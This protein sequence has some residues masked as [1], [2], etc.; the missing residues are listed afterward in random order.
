MTSYD[1]QFSEIGQGLALHAGRTAGRLARIR[2]ELSFASRLAA[3]QPEHA[4]G[5]RE[6]IL[7]AGRLVEEGLQ[8]SAPDIDVLTAE[9][10]ALLAPLGETAKRYTL[11][12][13]GHAHI[14]MNWQW[15]WP[16]TVALT[17]DTFQTMLTLMDEFPGFIFSQSQASVYAAIEKYDPPMFDLIRQRVAEGRWEVTASQWVEGDTNL[18]NGESISRHLLY[19]R[20]YFQKAFGLSPEDVTIDFEPDTFGHPATLPTILARG[21]VRH[22]YHCR[23]SRG[24][25]VYWWVGPDGSK[26]LVFNDIQW[27][28]HFDAARRHVAVDT[29]MADPLMEFAQATGLR[30][31]PVLYG[32]GD[33]GGGPTR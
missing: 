19:T 32:V 23:G 26:I 12:C 28:M 5:W 3:V 24:P 27:Y 1:A 22:Y 2:A 14:D 18:S 9:S 13:V 16:E 33:H 7:E 15:S 29:N 21:G 11:L 6:R 20:A 10:E 17:H 30:A 25:H 4:T 31:M 8:H